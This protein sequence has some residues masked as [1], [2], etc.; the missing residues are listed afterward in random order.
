MKEWIL[1]FIV[2]LKINKLFYFKVSF[3][4]LLFYSFRC[5]NEVDCPNGSDEEGCK[6]C[7][8]KFKC[9]DEQCID[10]SQ[11]CDG[12][13]QCNEG[14][15]ESNCCSG[16]HN[17]QCPG[18]GVCIPAKYLC[19]GW[20]HCADGADELPTFCAQRRKDSQ[21]PLGG[22]KASYIIGILAGI[23]GVT[24]MVWGVFYCRRRMESRNFPPDDRAC[25]PL[26]PKPHSHKPGG[27]CPSNSNGSRPMLLEGHSKS[28]SKASEGVRMSTLGMNSYDRNNITGAS[29]SVTNGSS[30]GGRYPREPLNPPPSPATTAPSSSAAS[31]HRPYRHYRLINQPPPPTPCSTD[32]CDESDCTVSYPPLGVGLY[33]EA[34]PPTPCPPSPPSPSSRSSTYFSPLPPPPSPVPPHYDS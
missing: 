17:F 16:P 10:L 7:P 34:P 5:D 27:V 23:A 25:D 26:S 15:D 32:V 1:L 11:V 13:K 30:G 2:A 21:Y 29:S 9:S 8:G 33:L 19:D 12:V 31:R 24:F 18:T 28:A 3:N 4:M 22:S 20:D 14:N 6:P